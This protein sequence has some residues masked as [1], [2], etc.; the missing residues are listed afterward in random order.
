MGFTYKNR[1][2]RL[3]S[4]KRDNVEGLALSQKGKSQQQIVRHTDV[5]VTRVN[6]ITM[7]D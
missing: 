1:H 6:R 5:Y 4:A 3:P 7:C 2:L